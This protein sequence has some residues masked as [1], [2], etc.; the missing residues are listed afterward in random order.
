MLVCFWILSAVGCASGRPDE[1]LIPENRTTYE[2]GEELVRSGESL[3]A[4]GNRLISDGDDLRK[5]GDK[6]IEEG[7]ERRERGEEMALRGNNALDAARML[8]EAEG[9]RRQGHELKGAA[10]PPE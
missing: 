8:E 7:R 10:F 9:L 3:I 1:F 4:E 2:H 6:M 5:Q